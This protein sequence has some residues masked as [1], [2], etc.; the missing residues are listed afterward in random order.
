MG[1]GLM[2]KNAQLCIL[3]NTI[4]SEGFSG[5]SVVVLENIRVFVEAKHGSERWAN[6]AA[7]SELLTYLDSERY[8]ILS[9]ILSITLCLTDLN[10]TFY[11]SR[12][13]KEGI[14]MLRC[15]LKKV[16]AS[17]G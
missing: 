17:N 6:L 5:H 7:F 1:L 8:L 12:M 13:S 14:C 16:E 4:D 2:N 10:M 9:L 15:L 11:Q 3:Q